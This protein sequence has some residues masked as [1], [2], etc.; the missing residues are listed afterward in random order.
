[1][2]RRIDPG[3]VFSEIAATQDDYFRERRDE[4]VLWVRGLQAASTPRE[5]MRLQLEL[6]D[7]FAGRQAGI[8][9]VND[10]LEADKSELKRA[11]RARIHARSSSWPNCRRGSKSASD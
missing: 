5:F 9:E 7:R 3:R 4:F 11:S 6:R 1:M 2:S 10:R 8:R